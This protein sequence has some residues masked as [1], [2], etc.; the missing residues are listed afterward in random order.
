MTE[1]DEQWRRVQRWY[2][3]VEAIS[4]GR[5]PLLHA[6]D[7]IVTSEE[8][9][10]SAAQLTDDFYALFQNC[11][12]LK[13]WLNHDASVSL[14]QPAND[15]INNSPDMRLCADLC[16]RTK[17]SELTTTRAGDK[18]I[19]TAQNVQVRIGVG[20][21]TSWTVKSGSTEID[22]F[23][24]ATRCVLEWTRYLRTEGLIS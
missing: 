7:R 2:R 9:F 18:N 13:D 12:H 19:A 5:V 24:L 4:Q 22:G 21:F 23:D 11:F 3:R 8:V 16:N 15:F 17:H 6:T 10:A 1:W 20:N 14:K